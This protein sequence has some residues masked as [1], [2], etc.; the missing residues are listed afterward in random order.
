M[1][2]KHILINYFVSESTK[3]KFTQHAE[4]VEISKKM[5]ASY[6]GGHF[7]PIS[8]A[9]NMS[10]KTLFYPCLFQCYA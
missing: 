10:I 7:L 9:D 8:A 5:T 6:S 4:S 1:A 3:T 2:Y